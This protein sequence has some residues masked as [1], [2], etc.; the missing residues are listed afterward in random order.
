MNI[1]PSL[2]LS[3]SLCHLA[4]NIAARGP[5][6]EKV[7]KPSTNPPTVGCF[8]CCTLGWF[9]FKCGSG[10][11]KPNVISLQHGVLKGCE[12]SKRMVKNAWERSYRCNKVFITNHF[13]YFKVD[14]ECA[15]GLLSLRVLSFLPAAAAR[16]GLV[17][18]STS[19]QQKKGLC[20][21]ACFWLF[22]SS[23]W[24]AEKNPSALFPSSLSHRTLETADKRQLL[25]NVANLQ[26]LQMQ[27]LQMPPRDECV[28]D[29]HQAGKAAAHYRRQKRSHK[30]T[31]RFNVSNF[32]YF[33]NPTSVNCL[34]KWSIMSWRFQLN[35]PICDRVIITLTLLLKSNLTCKKKLILQVLRTVFYTITLMIIKMIQPDTY[36]VT[37]HC[38][39]VG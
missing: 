10:V 16:I 17:F 5:V 26:M 4:G 2:C 28:P 32:L 14:S 36:D 34:P 37:C 19:C 21:F 11:R 38:L 23:A 33:Y 27:M 22:T 24:H 31:R 30:T 35:H 3:L 6:A 25:Q 8:L 12:M 13:S 18:F 7:A 29:I 1:Y 39:Y 9:L 20:W 15:T